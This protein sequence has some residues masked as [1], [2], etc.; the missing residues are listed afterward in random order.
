MGTVEALFKAAMDNVDLILL[1]SAYMVLVAAAFCL[2]LPKDFQ[3]KVCLLPSHTSP[4]SFPLDLNVFQV[5]PTWWV[6]VILLL[7]PPEKRLLSSGDIRMPPGACFIHIF[8]S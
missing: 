7:Q 4:G 6:G 1:E 3:S 5:V 2:S 8:G